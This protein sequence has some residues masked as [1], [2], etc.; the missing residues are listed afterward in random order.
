V[1]PKKQ[2][3]SHFFDE[4]RR[5]QPG[6]SLTLVR[7]AEPPAPDILAELSGMRVGVE[8]TKYLR[9]SE[10]HEEGE[11]D[12]ILREAQ[13]VYERAGNKPVSV[14]VHWAAAPSLEEAERQLL[15][16][17]LATAVGKNIPPLG[18]SCELAWGSL[19]PSLEHAIHHVRIDR[20]VDYITNVWQVRRV[21]VRPTLRADDVRASIAR[22]EDHIAN[23]L[24]HCDTAWLL[25]ACEGSGPSARCEVPHLTRE[26]RYPTRFERLF[27]LNAY[28]REVV[29]LPVTQENI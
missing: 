22:K 7:Q 5:L 8:I 15:V 19:P 6:L 17:A 18:R 27:F 10:K 11:E 25:I 3:E 26:T 28:P 16:D 23:Y 24:Q 2:Q 4:F 12:C 21:P 9:E 29:E 1:T 13:Q 20:L 14:T